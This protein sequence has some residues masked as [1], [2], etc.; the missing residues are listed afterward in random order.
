MAARLRQGVRERR[1]AKSG[2]P[3]EKKNQMTLVKWS[4]NPTHGVEEMDK[5]TGHQP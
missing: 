4:T 5:R 1:G 3:Q 2:R